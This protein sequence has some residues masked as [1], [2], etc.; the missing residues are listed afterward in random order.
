LLTTALLFT[1][2][3]LKEARNKKRTTMADKLNINFTMGRT[4]DKE[5][6]RSLM[7]DHITK[8]VNEFD[9]EICGE[10]MK[11]MYHEDLSWSQPEEHSLAI[12]PA[13]ASEDQFHHHGRAEGTSGASD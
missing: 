8:I 7:V 5:L 2:L 3:F 13:R 10:R 11:E 12:D 6:L 4:A 9:E 1:F